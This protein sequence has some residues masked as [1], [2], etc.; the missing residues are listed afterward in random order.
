MRF[1]G[2]ETEKEELEK[3]WTQTSRSAKLAVITGRRRLG[4]T[5]LVKEFAKNHNYIYFGLFHF[6][7]Q[8]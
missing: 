2:R 8:N 6:F 1:Y 4:K 3:L 5:L 7:A